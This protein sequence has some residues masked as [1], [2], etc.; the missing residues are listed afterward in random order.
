[1][2]GDVDCLIC[3]CR[4]LILFCLSVFGFG[5][6]RFECVFVRSV[7]WLSV[8]CVCGS[9]FE[10]L[11]DAVIT[12][13]VSFIHTPGVRHTRSHHTVLSVC[14]LVHGPTRAH[15]LGLSVP[16][17]RPRS[18]PVPSTGSRVRLNL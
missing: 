7:S 1:M 9:A 16:L 17:R 2:P 12:D 18:P 14:L 6:F 13:E 8:L 10:D 11:C 3:G 5:S 4:T 15:P